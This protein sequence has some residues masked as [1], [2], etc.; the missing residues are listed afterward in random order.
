MSGIL[1]HTAD[2]MELG[3]WGLGLL[4]L[5]LVVILQCVCGVRSQAIQKKQQHWDYTQTSCIKPLQDSALVLERE[6]AFAFF[7]HP[8]VWLSQLLLTFSS[9]WA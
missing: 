5:F 8:G 2:A 1:A 4:M 3:E 7:S 9:Y 6:D